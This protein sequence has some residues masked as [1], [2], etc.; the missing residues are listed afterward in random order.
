MNEVLNLFTSESVTE[1]HPDKMADQISDAILDAI[2]EKD[3]NARVAC[4]TFITNKHIIIGGEITTTAD[5]DYEQ[6]ARD[7]I[8][9]IGLVDDTTGVSHD[10]YDIKV[11]ISTQSPDINQGVDLENGDI[12]AGDQGIMFGYATNETK[13]YMPVAIYYAHK[14]A[15]QLATVRK[16]K[17]LDYLLPDGKTQVT[18]EYNDKHQ[19]QRISAIV[20]STQH[21]EGV[22]QEQI[23]KDVI[24]YVIKP[25]IPSHLLDENTEFHIN[26]TGKFV[27]GGSIGDAGLTGRKIIVDTYGGAAAHGGGAFSGKDYTKVDRSAAYMARYLAKNIVASGICDRCQIQLSYVIGITKPMSVNVICFGTNKVDE[28]SITKAIL[29]NFD[30]SPKGIIE[31]LDLTKPQYLPTASYG[32]FGNS[33]FNWEQLNDVEIFK[34]LLNIKE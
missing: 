18:V 8:K 10:T 27:I 3:A 30:L 15:K 26:P 6:V 32:H 21:R 24:E 12:G 7:V 29:D 34:N 1:G 28:L 17:Q 9:N 20:V 5:I 13:D 33:Q 16:N 14:L 11:L 2:L 4:E 19:V 25:I 22:S 23:R 31:K